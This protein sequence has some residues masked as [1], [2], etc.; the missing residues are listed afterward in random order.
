MA[1]RIIPIK[2]VKIHERTTP[3]LKTLTKRIKKDGYVIPVVVDKRHK[4]LLD[5]HH[6]YAALKKLGYKKIPAYLVDYSNVKVVTR[7]KNVEITREK[8][9]T[10]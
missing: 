4:I 8:N 7:R 10:S 9:A 3:K 5:G 6:R 2:S 1:Y